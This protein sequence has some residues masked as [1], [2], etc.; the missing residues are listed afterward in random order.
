MRLH[1]ISGLVL[2]LCM[3]LFCTTTVFA[4]SKHELLAMHAVKASECH[5][6]AIN[7]LDL[8]EFDTM[9]S[10]KHGAAKAEELQVELRKEASI[11]M[12]QKFSKA[13]SNHFTDNELKSIIENKDVLKTQRMK[14]KYVSAQT[15]AM[16]SISNSSDEIFGRFASIVMDFVSR[17]YSTDKE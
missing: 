5:T 4:F 2:A 12:Q 10:K 9:I 13:F 11:F 14:S 17:E 3:S 16:S 1:Y 8:S 15:E 7:R 6:Q